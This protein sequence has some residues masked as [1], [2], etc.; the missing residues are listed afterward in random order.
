M[1]DAALPL[2][3]H[4]A[5][6]QETTAAVLVLH[7]GKAAS[8]EATRPTQLTARRMRPFARAIVEA[9][10]DRQVAVAMLRYRVRGWNDDGSPVD[11]ARWALD[12]VRRDHGDV[13]VVLVGHS[14]GG[15]T[16]LRVAGH[17]SVI[18]VAALAPWLPEGEPVEQLA[19]RTVLIVHGTLDTLTSPRASLVYARRAQRVTS[20]VCRVELRCERH[21]MLWRAHLWH[22][23]VAGFVAGVLEHEAMPAEIANALAHGSNGAAAAI[24]VAD[25]TRVRL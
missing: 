21:G 16:A 18:A 3:E 11:D 25:P 22:R 12:E 1:P 23:L 19:G 4:F 7:G 8:T 2:L 9:T 24:G 14:M 17:D 10:H 13:P 6:P 20:A 15:R 5:Q